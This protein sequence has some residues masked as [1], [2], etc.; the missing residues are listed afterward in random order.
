MIPDNPYVSCTKIY[1][2]DKQTA[3]NI[4]KQTLRK[5]DMRDRLR[6]KLFKKKYQSTL[7]K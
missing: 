6:A 3:M 7:N 5:D 2:H 4:S 1:H